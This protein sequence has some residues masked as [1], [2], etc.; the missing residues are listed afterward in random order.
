MHNEPFLIL[1][2]TISP[3]RYLKC[4][5]STI[6]SCWLKFKKN[7]VKEL[8]VNKS[9]YYVMFYMCIRNHSF[10]HSYLHMYVLYNCI[11]KW[12]ALDII[13]HLLCKIT[14][15]SLKHKFVG[16]KKAFLKS[17]GAVAPTAPT[18]IM[19]L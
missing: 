8:S 9:V 14:S 10:K 16:A 18:L 7:K 12:A 11:S 19:P 6:K 3:F 17:V 2:C 1:T 15:I 13:H 4:E 5:K